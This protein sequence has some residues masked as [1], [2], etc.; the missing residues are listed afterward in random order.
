[1]IPPGSSAGSAS[2][3]G[4]PPYYAFGL[5]FGKGALPGPAAAPPPGAGVRHRVGA[6]TR[7]IESRFAAA[8]PGDCCVDLR[9]ADPSPQAAQWLRQSHAQRGF[10]A[11]VPR[12]THRFHAAPLVPAREYDGIAFVARSTCSRPLPR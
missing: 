7:F 8:V 11:G 1:M 6:G 9:A 4:T 5:L 2:G 10:G 3:P 12:W